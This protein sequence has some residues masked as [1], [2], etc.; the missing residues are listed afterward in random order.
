[1]LPLRTVRGRLLLGIACQA[2]AALA[3]V[4]PFIAVAE[5]GRALLSG[6]EWLL[7]V[8]IG[9]AALPV[10]V[11]SLTAATTLT[12]FADND[13]QLHVRRELARH[14]S[15][16]PLGWL[17]ARGS[18]AVKQAVHDDVGAL[19]HLV[20]HALLD[21]VSALVVP[22]AA[23][24]Y[25]FTV[26][27]WMTVITLVPLALGFAFRFRAMRNVHV[28]M[29]EYH[30]ATESLNTASVEFVHGIAVVKTF[31]QTGE[32][33]SRFREAAR[34]YGKF[35]SDWA[36]HV[37]PPLIRSQIVQAPLVALVVVLAA[38]TALSAGGLL[39]PADLVPFLVLGTGLS[40]PALA[41]GYSLQELRAGRAAADRISAV[42]ATPPLPEGT[43]AAPLPISP[44]RVE[45]ASVHFG[46]D[47]ETPVLRGID[48]VLEPDTVTALVGPSGAGKST[49]AGLLG[50]FH[51][52]SDGSVRINGADVRDLPSAELYRRV[53]FVLQ[54]VRLLNTTVL[55]NI[56]LASPEADEAAVVRAAKAAR[57]HDRITALPA[58]Y[59]TVLGDDVHLSGGEAQRVCVAR[60]LLA[61]TPV[62]VLD[63]ATSFAD[64]E[65]EA[66][67]QEAV[68]E[69]AVGRTVLVIAHR[70]TTVRE[71]DQIVVLE[72][73][74]IRERG[75]HDDLLA[76]NGTY[77]SM[78]TVT[79]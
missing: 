4:A 8:V 62:L 14:V 31:G 66:E 56:R 53:G 19:H 18:G 5:T 37:T 45:F 44:A 12:H 3:G 21:L 77:A 13:L 30:R 64:A 48:L 1:M 39:L 71:A 32:G 67:I 68:G 11:I 46:Y 36:E 69:L 20:A 65:S 6:E 57:I 76:A 2:T 55:D 59:L 10:R 60:A 33:H 22:I 73:G 26:N 42:L 61:D 52:V 7:Y 29:A 24:V 35:V 70:L 74:V 38:G 40:G 27:P 43:G 58:G 72:D 17:S 28:R 9:I 34:T 75:T 41:I 51:D 63:E 78:W 15:R 79:R 49:L 54:D 25:L 47:A 50:R 16:L 23:T